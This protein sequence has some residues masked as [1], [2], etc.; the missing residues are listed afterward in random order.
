MDI[1]IGFTP[2]S[3][4]LRHRKVTKMVNLGE[5]MIVDLFF[6]TP[7]YTHFDM[8]QPAGI[9]CLDMLSVMCYNALPF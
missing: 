8:C 6:L 4:L 5:G 1:S 2:Y 9:R 7:S 3:L